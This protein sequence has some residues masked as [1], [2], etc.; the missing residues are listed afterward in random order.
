MRRIDFL[1]F[2]LSLIS[3]VVF[4]AIALSIRAEAQKVEDKGDGDAP[5]PAAR[6][7]AAVNSLPLVLDQKMEIRVASAPFKAGDREYHRLSIGTGTFH[8]NGSHLTATLKAGV[9]EDAN[10]E[11]FIYAA[12]FDAKGHLLGTASH[13]EKVQYISLGRSPMMLSDIALDFGTS[14]D[15]KSAATVAVTISNPD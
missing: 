8:L 11:Y 7:V 10:V 15:F 6:S 2:R 1:S 13:K 5:P 4:A 3:L 14:R 12:V 9:L